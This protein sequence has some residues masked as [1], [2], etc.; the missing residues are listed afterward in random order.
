MEE[1][2]QVVQYVKINGRR[3]SRPIRK[4]PTSLVRKK[5]DSSLTGSSD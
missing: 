3:Y 1:S 5:L 2:N 4:V